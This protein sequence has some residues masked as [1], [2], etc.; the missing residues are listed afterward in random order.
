MKKSIQKPS[1]KTTKKTAKGVSAK[2]KACRMLSTKN[3]GSKNAARKK[4][5]LSSRK[6]KV[7]VMDRNDSDEDSLDFDNM[8]G[9][10]EVMTEI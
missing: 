6:G 9:T 7:V 3:A 10:R 1:A 5:P 8:E 4:T 2:A